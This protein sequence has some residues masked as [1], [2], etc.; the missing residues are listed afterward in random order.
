[1]QRAENGFI[2]EVVQIEEREIDPSM[3]VE[4]G[5]PE[6]MGAIRAQGM[7]KTRTPVSKVFV[8][9]SIKDALKKL[10]EYFDE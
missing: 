9:T 1:M 8:Y 5:E 10:E 6:A 2:V 4:A 7:P 3:L